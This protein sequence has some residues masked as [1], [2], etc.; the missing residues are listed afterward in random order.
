MSDI[1]R[2][3][4]AKAEFKLT[5]DEFRWAIDLAKIE[6]AERIIRLIKAL[7]PNETWTGY[8]EKTIKGEQR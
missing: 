7:Y 3:I 2:Y 1:G 5:G 6:E 8:L 4:P